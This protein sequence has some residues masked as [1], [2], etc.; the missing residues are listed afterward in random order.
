MGDVQNYEPVVSVLWSSDGREVDENG[1]TIRSIPDGWSVGFYDR[2]TVPPE[3]V[4]TI[5]GIPFVLDNCARCMELND[6]V[7]DYVDG[8][9]RVV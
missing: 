7:L 4:Q 8:H 2:S 6:K 5:D 1:R 3:Y 9:F